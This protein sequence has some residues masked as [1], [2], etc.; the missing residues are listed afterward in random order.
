M[1][2]IHKKSKLLFTHISVTRLLVN[3]VHLMTKNQYAS[4][5]Y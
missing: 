2:R 1:Y 5:K 4:T 3:F